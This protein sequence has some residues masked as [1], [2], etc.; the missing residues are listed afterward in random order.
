MSPLWSQLAE[1]TCHDDPR[2]SLTCIARLDGEDVWH[3]LGEGLVVG[4][5][6]GAAVAQQDRADGR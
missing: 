2:H 1:L 6:Q 4:W 3:R 5:G